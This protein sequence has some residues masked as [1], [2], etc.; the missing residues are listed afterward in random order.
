MS[1]W[2]SE[3]YPSPETK[4]SIKIKDII[5][6]QLSEYQKVEIMETERLGKLLLL[7]GFIMLSELDEFVYHEM[8]V[9]PA[10][11][12]HPNPQ[13][14]L[15]VGGGDGGTIREVLKHFSVT[16]ALLVEIDEMV[17][18]ACLQHIPSVASQLNNPKVKKYFEDAVEFV[19]KT[20]EKFDVIL[21][22]S[23]DPIS[24]GEGLFT[25]EFY[26]NCKNILNEDGILIAQSESAFYTPHLVPNIYQKIKSVFKDVYMFRASIPTYPSGDWYFTYASKKEIDK[27]KIDITR[28]EKLVQGHKLKYY[29]KNIH[30]AAFALPNFV[31]DILQQK[32]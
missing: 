3:Y 29:N 23:T 15:V 28:Y 21:I 8:I 16:E 10:L 13:K 24:I 9:H 11:L 12:T 30:K 6:S 7:D 5:F 2:F 1:I 22:D 20:E 31:L 14:V 25:K 17:S 19:K 32:R 18:D 27:E 4:L 26:Q